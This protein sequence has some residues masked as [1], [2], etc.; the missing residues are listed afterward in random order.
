LFKRQ[1][2][3]ALGVTKTIPFS[4]FR[5]ILL[6]HGAITEFITI[7]ATTAWFGMRKNAA[8]SNNFN[9][10][11][12]STGSNFPG[13]ACHFQNL[14]PIAKTYFGAFLLTFFKISGLLPHHSHSRRQEIFASGLWNGFCIK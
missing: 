11:F 9:G 5:V 10:E 8:K 4:P 12:F 1:S 13:N 7:L 3:S 2:A 6:Q 14:S